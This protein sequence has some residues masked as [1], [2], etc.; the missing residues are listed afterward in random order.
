MT[1]AFTIIYRSESV[2]NSLRGVAILGILLLAFPASRAA[3]PAVE[4]AESVSLPTIFGDLRLRYDWP[5]GYYYAHIGTLA[6]NASYSQDDWARFGR[7]PQSDVK[8][9]E[10]RATDVIAKNLN[11]AARQ[12]LVDALTTIQDGKRLHVDLNWK[13]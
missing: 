11:L 3:T 8:G 7:G 10:I 4:P 6:V 13:F 12:F 5:F 1:S 9:H 2:R